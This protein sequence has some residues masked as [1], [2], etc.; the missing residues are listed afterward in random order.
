MTL[1]GKK[2]H[3]NVKLLHGCGVS[4]SLKNN[5]IVLQNGRDIFSGI[6]DVEEWFVTN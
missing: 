2:N 6:S 4:I 3:Y 5:R 1:R